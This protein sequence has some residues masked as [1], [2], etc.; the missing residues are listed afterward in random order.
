M[1]FEPISE[2]QKIKPSES[3]GEKKAPIVGLFALL[4]LRQRLLWLQLLLLHMLLL[5]LKAIRLQLEVL[6]R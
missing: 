3:I 2:R 1:T 4:L 6:L 5:E